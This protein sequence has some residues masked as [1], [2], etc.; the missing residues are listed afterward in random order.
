[1]GR[2]RARLLAMRS[3]V[4]RRRI[5]RVPAPSLLGRARGVKVD[6]FCQ[7]F[8]WTPPAEARKNACSR[9]VKTLLNLAGRKSRHP[10]RAVLSA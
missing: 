9:Q 5:T 6:L 3:N 1:M 2:E 4:V 8:V 7:P 10:L